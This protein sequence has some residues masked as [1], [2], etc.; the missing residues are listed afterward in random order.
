MDADSTIGL[1]VKQCQHAPPLKMF[2]LPTPAMAKSVVRVMRYLETLFDI[3]AFH[4]FSA[5]L[6][7]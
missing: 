2:S 3:M 6:S 7:S 4:Y 1:F 5:C